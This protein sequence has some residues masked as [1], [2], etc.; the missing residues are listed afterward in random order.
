MNT[1]GSFH[2]AFSLAPFLLGGLTLTILLLQWGS[3]SLL[4]HRCFVLFVWILTVQALGGVLYLATFELAPFPQ[5]LLLHLILSSLAVLSLHFY[6][7]FEKREGKVRF[8]FA[9]L[10]TLGS[11]VLVGA[12][13]SR[14]G[15]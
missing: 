11:L 6:H 14:L 7:R 10:S 5:G 4:A 15:N 9:A 12:S 8:L 1:L 13:F 2:V 3:Y